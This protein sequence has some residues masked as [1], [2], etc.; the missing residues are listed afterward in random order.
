VIKEK[1]LKLLVVTPVF[2]GEEFLEETINSVLDAG[3]SSMEFV[4]VNDGSTDGTSQIL[5]K[6]KGRIKII[7]QPNGGEGNAVNKGFAALDSEYIMVVSADD[8][9]DKSIF[10]KLVKVLDENPLYAVAYPDWEIIDKNGETISKIETREFSNK[11]LY[12]KMKC[13]PGPGALIRRSAVKR[14][15]LRDDSYI[16][17]GDFECWLQI[18]KEHQFVRVPEYLAKWRH[19]GRNMSIVGRNLQMASEFIRV[20][21]ELL[22][23]NF[24]P[25]QIKPLV[26]KGL[27]TAYYTAARLVYFDEKVPAR[28]YILK[29]FYWNLTLRR[30]IFSLGYI[31]AGR[32]I[33]IRLTPILKKVLRNRL[34]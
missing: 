4:V 1:A 30:D 3:V 19:H 12:E 20:Y 5:Q 11:I 24:L 17:I 18:A 27:G 9:I 13:L 23:S 29:S 6:F 28:K 21:K 26:E 2:N 15:N 10:N 16:F 31:L 7:D 32:R 34:P 14:S 25:S 8:L 22:S 33:G